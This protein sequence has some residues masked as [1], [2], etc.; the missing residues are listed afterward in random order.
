MP[1]GTRSHQ[2]EMRPF[3]LGA[4]KTSIRNQVDIIPIVASP[5]H[6][7]IDLNKI[8]SGKVVI[9]FLPPLSTK[10]LTSIDSEK[11]AQVTRSSMES[12]MVGMKG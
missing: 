6:G 8:N 9:Q 3:K 5:W 2:Y 4:F 10:G 12:V 7:K 11:L 1:E